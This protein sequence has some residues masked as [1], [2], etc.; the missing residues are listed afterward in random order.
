MSFFFPRTGSD[1]LEVNTEESGIEGVESWGK[2]VRLDDRLVCFH[3]P[4]VM[5][6]KALLSA[7]SMIRKGF[8]MYRTCCIKIPK[9]LI[10]LNHPC[11][12]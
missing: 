3:T 7:R 5:V 2:R 6:R 9:L 4:C 10:F 11:V 8:Y 12:T 1:S